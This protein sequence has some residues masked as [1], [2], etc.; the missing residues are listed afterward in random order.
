MSI[1]E[2][3]FDAT[4]RHQ[5]YL[6]RFGGS[7]A[8]EAV[9]LLEAAEKD[10]VERIAARVEKMGPAAVDNQTLRLQ[11]VLKDIRK[12]GKDLTR[13]LRKA[14]TDS[15]L[16]LAEQEVDISSARI[17]QAIGV[18]MGNFRPSPETL[19]ALVRD[20]G[21]AGKTLGQWYKRLGDDRVGRLE[22]AVSLGI[23][24]GRTTP[25]IIRSFRE[26]EMVSKRSA[27]SLVRTHVNHVANQSREE[28]YKANDDLI[29]EVR[30]TS[31]LDGRTS[32]ICSSRDGHTWRL[33]EGPR[34]PAHPNC[35]SVMVP[36][37]KSWKEIKEDGLKRG[38]GSTDIEEKF[39]Q[40]LKKMDI[41]P[42]TVIQGARASMNGQVPGSLSY[43][44][45]LRRQP[46]GFVED[47]LGET[48][49]K[50]F[51]EG[52]LKLDRFVDD[53]TARTF[54]IDEVRR[55][56]EQVWM[57]VFPPGG[58]DIEKMIGRNALQRAQR[59]VDLPRRRRRDLNEAELDEIEEAITK[60]P[61]GALAKAKAQLMANGSWDD[62]SS[63]EKVAQLKAQEAQFKKQAAISTQLSK[64]KKNMVEGKPL[65]PAMDN[66]LKTLD[67]ESLANFHAAVGAIQAESAAGQAMAAVK[68]DGAIGNLIHKQMIDLDMP[69]GQ[70][71]SAMEAGLAGQKQAA[72]QITDMIDAPPGFQSDAFDN[73]M[74]KSLSQFADEG[75]LPTQI[76]DDINAEVAALKKADASE[77][78]KILSAL[79][80]DSPLTLKVM[81]DPDITEASFKT[82]VAYANAVK[83]KFD[84]EAEWDAVINDH[85][86]AAGAPI[87]NKSAYDA[88]IGDTHFDL[89]IPSQKVKW[90]EDLAEKHFQSAKASGTAGITA[91]DAIAEINK[92][93]AKGAGKKAYEKIADKDLTPQ[94][95]LAELKAEE[96]AVK[97]AQASAK[98][99]SKA[100]KNL[101]EGKPLTPAMQEA[102]DEFA[103]FLLDDVGAAALVETAKEAVDTLP[104]S[105]LENIG[106]KPGGSVPGYLAR[107]KTTGEK[108]IVKRPSEGAEVAR[109][110]VL[111][112]KLY[113]AAGVDVPELMLVTFD[114]GTIG[115]ASKVIDQID[116]N[117]LRAIVDDGAPARGGAVKAIHE[118][119][120][121]DAWL[122]NWDVAGLSYDNIAFLKNAPIRIDVGGAL[123]F[124]A[125]GGLKHNWDE[126]VDEMDSLRDS[127]INPQAARLFANTTK[128]QIETG[129]SKVLGITDDVI[130]DL[131]EQFGPME[132]AARKEMA[133]I[134]KGR[135]DDLGKRYPHLKPEARVAAAPKRA[136]TEAL[137]K[138]EVEAVVTGRA[139]GYS[140]LTDKG[141]IE[142]NEI[143]IWTERYGRQ[144][145]T[146][147][148][149]KARGALR[150]KLDR[151]V[152]ASSGDPSAVSLEDLNLKIVQLI[153]G[154]KSNPQLREVDI[155]RA[156]AV[157]AEWEAIQAKVAGETSDIVDIFGSFYADWI[158]GAQKIA[159]MR[160]GEEA[161]E[162]VNFGMFGGALKVTKVLPKASKET[163]SWTSKHELEVKTADKGHLK[164]APNKT[165]ETASS[166]S[167]KEA[168][169][170]GHRVRYWY[171]EGGMHGY[172]E[173]L[174]DK[175]PGAVGDDLFRVMD[176][177]GVNSK[178]ATPLDLEQ[179]YLE[180]HYFARHETIPE[181][182]GK[183]QQDHIASM[184]ADLSKKTGYPIDRSPHYNPEG[185]DNGFGHGHRAF[186]RA[187]LDK[188]LNGFDKWR[189]SHNAG[190]PL[191]VFKKIFSEGGMF[192]PK[193]DWARRGKDFASVGM[194]PETDMARGGGNYLYTTL[195]EGTTRGQFHWK[196]DTVARRLDIRNHGHDPVGSIDP[197][198]KRPLKPNRPEDW[199]T[200]ET[201]IKNGLSFFTDGFTFNAGSK[202]SELIDW[203][204]AQGEPFRQGMWP[205][206]R[207]L[208]EVIL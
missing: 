201:V 155:T 60:A 175:A 7:M 35:R 14:G 13:A 87:H 67:D 103:P 107:H 98:Q 159:A 208:E 11:A 111:A 69:I 170:N 176:E 120:A 89:L 27:T 30:W 83:K 125:Q 91:D 36:V 118:N 2:Q 59:A 34:P 86:A 197:S 153:K 63:A 151:M 72:M 186:R 199:D 124:R 117:R 76:L 80:E 106:S 66:A 168:T 192:A 1:N 127:G 101:A 198:I 49:S 74:V 100:K 92:I 95:F 48:K 33:D 97:K 195:K 169:V 207:R 84:V 121:V 77:A 134:L 189:F 70:K 109:N 58:P 93:K 43:D 138:E 181:S 123:R 165:F 122:A 15:L 10:L 96:A 61:G 29:K 142:D 161:A 44:D 79:D 172:V 205:D 143:L 191:T 16:E 21:V 204:K 81:G 24:E 116:T 9:K 20:K 139:Q 203:I 37:T 65:T 166:T 146:A 145:K 99:L 85:Y 71:A 163:I 196:G 25:E 148:R 130:D 131:V 17:N 39:H 154:V 140:R 73:V 38:R 64:A 22:S 54:T 46:V 82:E 128:R 88:L 177:L 173:I 190:N 144:D 108:W 94:A 28:F 18:D 188:G 185:I 178:R 31:T 102:V 187:D 50:L 183:S 114:D 174:S 141:D 55:K 12:Q 132:S 6:I 105:L 57:Q 136:A 137:T 133:R 171:N 51:L 164:V 42:A 158:T 53:A 126:I 45:W 160:I 115:L 5:I 167:Y 3:L 182:G 62:L 78:A 4:N 75:K 184:K 56:N 147:A 194:S 179:T 119:Y 129:V 90:L 52:G 104:A 206:G 47:L 68:A 41:D 8:A 23:L 152:G 157:V 135:R 193:T 19:K 180:K 110:E 32:L 156:K 26:A 40:E 112:A 149:F 200:Y 202:R 162:H 113:E 150:D